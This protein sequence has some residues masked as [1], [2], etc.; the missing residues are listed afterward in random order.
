MVSSGKHSDGP[1]S[2]KYAVI[3]PETKGNSPHSNKTQGS[4]FPSFH[5]NRVLNTAIKQMVCIYRLPQL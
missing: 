5:K 2:Q 4:L 3:K 1:D